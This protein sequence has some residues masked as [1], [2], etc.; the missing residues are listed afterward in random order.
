MASY[1]FNKGFRSGKFDIAIDEAARYGYF[2]HEDL[3]DE[4]GGGLWFEENEDGK[5]ELY[6]QDGTSSLPFSVATGLRKNGYIVP[7]EFN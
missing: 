4:C 7:D 5:L 2:E 6:D 1:N 3:G